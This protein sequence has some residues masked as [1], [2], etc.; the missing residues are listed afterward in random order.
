LEIVRLDPEAQRVPYLTEAVQCQSQIERASL[1]LQEAWLLNLQW[2]LQR[3]PQVEH[4]G[5]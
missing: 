3:V 4:E 2:E 1:W 5:Q